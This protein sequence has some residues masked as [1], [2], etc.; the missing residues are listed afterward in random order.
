MQVLAQGVEVGRALILCQKRPTQTQMCIDTRLKPKH[1]KG[2]GRYLCGTGNL[3]MAYL[4]CRSE[5]AGSFL[6]VSREGGGG[7]GQ[8]VADG[9]GD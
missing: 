5:R 1:R 3:S 2:R 8:G 6:P 7:R 4:S 9:G